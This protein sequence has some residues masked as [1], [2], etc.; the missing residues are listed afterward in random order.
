MLLPRLMSGLPINVQAD[1]ANLLPPPDLE[2][3]SA[4]NPIPLAFLSPS[5]T[6]FWEAANKFQEILGMGGFEPENVKKRAAM[7][8]AEQQDDTFKDDN[9]EAYWGERLERDKKQKA[10]AERAAARGRGGRGR[11]GSGGGGAAGRDKGKAKAV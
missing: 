11:G 9:Y 10:K 4:S 7:R 5:N 3:A 6:H 8:A 2:G 1:L